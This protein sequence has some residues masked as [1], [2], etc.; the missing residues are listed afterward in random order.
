M[1]EVQR[2]R[3]GLAPGA[4]LERNPIEEENRL[5]KNDNAP[6]TH[7]LERVNVMLSRELILWLGETALSIRQDSGASI[8]R[9]ELI[10]AC[11]R[12][13]AALQLRFSSIRSE[14]ELAGALVA[15]FRGLQRGMR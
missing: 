2:A 11:L 14:E 1:C 9:S 3:Q 13:L 4:E 5:T 10:R 15:Y 6:P 7:S 12:A 8:S